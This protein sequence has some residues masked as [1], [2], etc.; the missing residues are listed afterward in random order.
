MGYTLLKMHLHGGVSLEDSSLQS[1]E[2]D[3]PQNQFHLRS[4]LDLSHKL[5]WD[6]A[7][8]YV[9]SLSSLEVPS[10]VQVDTRFAW[11][12]TE[13]LEVSLELQNLLDDRHQEFGSGFLVS[14]TEIERGVYG[15][16]T[17]KF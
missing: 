3:S 5:N 10:Y 6:V 2:G 7:L 17:W 13:T 9:D 11:Y 14:P 16:I 4:Y 12:P 1:A 8:Y 15:K